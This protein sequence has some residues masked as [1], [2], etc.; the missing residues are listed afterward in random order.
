TLDFDSELIDKAIFNKDTNR[1]IIRNLMEKGLK[2]ADNQLPGK[3]IIFARSI[4]HADLLADLFHE[5]YPD[6]GG[7][8]CR[9]IH[10]KYE[11]AEDLIDN[12]K[13]TEGREDDITIA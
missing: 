2:D 3:S 10:S 5:M 7:N 12:F 1:A 4:A 6:L 11:R 9:V 13:S 8:F